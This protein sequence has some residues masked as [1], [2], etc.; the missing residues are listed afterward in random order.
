MLKLVEECQFSDFLIKYKEKGRGGDFTMPTK[1]DSQQTY[2][3]RDYLQWGEGRCE[4]IKGVV[5]D[6]TPAPSRIHQGVSARLMRGIMNHL[7]VC[8]SSCEAYAAPFD[9][10]LPDADESD[11]RITTVVQPDISVICDPSKLDDRGCRGAPDWIIEI[12]S[13]STASQD[14]IRKL[15]LYEKQCVREYWIV[16]PVDKIV[17]VYRMTE[18]GG[19][20]RPEIYSVK[21]RVE[22]QAVAGLMIELEEVFES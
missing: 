5:H 10:R 1:T 3:Y 20:G 21:D 15:A 18:A 2:T 22:A 11:D 8:R 9:V 16:H 4:L 14:Y 13:P 12:V 7:V 17:T 6:M 19:Y